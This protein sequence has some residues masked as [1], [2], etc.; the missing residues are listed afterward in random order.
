LKRV[1]LID[2]LD[3]RGPT[4]LAELAAIVALWFFSGRR[5]EFSAFASAP[6]GVSSIVS[7][8]RLV[9]FRNM[10]RERCKKLQRIELVSCTVFGGIGNDIVL[11]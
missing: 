10:R 5:G 8:Y 4:T 7:S 3:A 11:D 2:A 9:G 1:D 6:T